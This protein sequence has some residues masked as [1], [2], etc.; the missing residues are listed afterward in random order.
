VRPGEVILVRHTGELKRNRVELKPRTKPSE[1]E[2]RVTFR[3]DDGYRPIFVIDADAQPDQTIFKL[4]GGEVTFEN[5]HFHLRP[6]QPKGGQ[7]V[8]AVALLGGKSCTFNNCV[9]TLA[10]DDD[11]KVAAVHLPDI[12]RVMVMKPETRQAPEVVFNGCLIRGRGRAVWAQT[13]RPVNLK[14]TNTLTAVNGP[15]LLT[16]AGDKAAGGSSTAKFLRVTALV[17]GPVVEMRGTKTGDAMR[18]SGLPM[19]KV[20]ADRCLFVAIKDAGKPLLELDAVDPADWKTVLT[21]QVTMME[22]NRYSHF[23]SSPVLALIRPGGDGAEKPWTRDEWIGNVGEPAGAD[24]RFGTVT[25]AAPLPGLNE[26]FA[27]KPADIVAKSFD[28]PDLTGAKA[29][30]VGVDPADLKKLPLA[31]DEPRP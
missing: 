23:D 27:V 16:E 15:V 9:F 17:G 11:S 30:D 12:A 24:K 8:A 6:G 1:G 26:L 3:A 31:P 22:G 29:L 10:E 14:M 2:F 25:F 4:L 7:T 28:F 18:A 13:S 5:I 19:L 21:W 20:D